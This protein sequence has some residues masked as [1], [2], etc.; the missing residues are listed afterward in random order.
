[1]KEN[2]KTCIKPNI[3]IETSKNSNN[4]YE[5]EYVIFVVFGFISKAAQS[6]D[7]F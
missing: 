1:M 3:G 4:E 5:Y 7:A 6:M 2:F